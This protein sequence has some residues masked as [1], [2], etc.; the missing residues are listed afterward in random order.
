MTPEE[1][2]ADVDQLLKHPDMGMASSYHDAGSC[3]QLIG[4]LRRRIPL[5]VAAE[6]ERC[7]KAMEAWVLA[8]CCTVCAMQIGGYRGIGAV[9]RKGTE[10]ES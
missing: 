8:E 1:L 7:A 4:A 2:E 10:C 5:A 6:R 9:I 3:W